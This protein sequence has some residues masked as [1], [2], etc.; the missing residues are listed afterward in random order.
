MVNVGYVLIAMAVLVVLTE[1]VMWILERKVFGPRRI[2]ANV[3]VLQQ[4]DLRGEMGLSAE[5]L[6]NILRVKGHRMSIRQFMHLMRDLVDQGYVRTWMGV[7]P[8]FEPDPRFAVTSK[9]YP[10]FKTQ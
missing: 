1:L 6:H 10:Y 2:R 5:H 4:L 8:G 7:S 9:P 3:I